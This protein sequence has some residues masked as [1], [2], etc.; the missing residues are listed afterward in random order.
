MIAARIAMEFC[1][2]RRVPK[3]V[4]TREVISEFETY[5]FRS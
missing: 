2:S 4:R 3:C 1:G 5:A